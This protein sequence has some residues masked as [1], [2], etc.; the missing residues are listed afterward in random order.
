MT[1]KSET[2]YIAFSDDGTAIRF[3]TRD[4][5]AAEDW[6]ADNG[7]PMTAYCATAWG[8]KLATETEEQK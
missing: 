6:S 5:R 2:L 4:T 3:W 1:Q 8:V 7:V